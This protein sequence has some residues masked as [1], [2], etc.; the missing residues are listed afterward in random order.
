MFFMGKKVSI[1]CFLVFLLFGC[2][3]TDEALFRK[4]PSSKTT[5]K[6]KNQLTATPELNIL[7]YL[8]FYNGGGVAAG[9]FNNDNLID[10][11]FTSNQNEDKLY[12]NK[13]DFVFQDVTT[14]SNIDNETGWTTGVTHVDINND[15]L[16]DLYVCK[17]DNDTNIKGRNLLYINQGNDASGVPTFKEDAISYGIGFSGFST[18][19]A[20]FDFDLD[21][22]LDMFLLNHSAHPNRTYGK[23]SNRN[24]I[25]N[26][27]GDRL[28]RN[29]E[30]HFIDISAEAGI[31][32]GNIGYGLGLSLSDIN[33]DGYPDIYVGNDFFEN[34][35]LYINQ[36]D[37]TF[38]EQISKNTR[39]FGHTSHFSMGNDIAD[40]N[41]DGLTDIVSLDML[42]EDLKTY[43]TSGL[44]YAYPT[45]QQYLKNGYHPQYMQNT[46]HLN[47]GENTFS[48]IANLSG[49]SASEWSWGA[50]LADFDN[51][52]YKDLYVS[53]GIQGA[54]NDMDFINFI[55]NDNIQQRISKGMTN[56]DM[57]FIDEIPQKKVSNYFF[58][59]T[60]GRSF[61]DVTKQWFTPETSFSN[62]C[63]YADLDNDGDL[64]I[65]VNNVNEEAYILQNNTEKE[66][67][68]KALQVKLKGN[69]KNTFGIGA[70]IIAFNNDKE[71]SVENFPARGYLSSVSNRL[72]VGVGNDSII[73]SLKIVWPNGYS[74]KLKQVPTNKIINLD[75]KNAKK[76]KFQKDTIK[77]SLLFKKQNVAI[78]FIHSEKNSIEFDRDPL[79]PF[80]STNEGPEISV[81]DIDRN[82]LE[83]FFICGAKAQP[84]A[85]YFQKAEGEFVKAQESLF[86]KD[87]LNED[88]S[89]IFF[90]A[91]GDGF[92][93]LL[94]VSG[95]NEFKST[96]KLWPRL[97]INK[98]GEFIKDSLQFNAI[99]VN[100][101][102]VL[103]VDFDNDSD[104]DVVITSDQVP[105]QFGKTPEQY[106]FENDGTGKFQN[107]TKKIA[108]DF[109]TI[110]NVKDM[111]WIDLNN[112]DFKDLVVVGHWMPISIFL[113]NGKSLKLQKSDDI[114]TTNGWWNAIKAADFDNDGDIDIVAG[115]WG[116]NSKFNASLEKPITLYSTDFDNNGSIEPLVTYFYKEK[117]TPFASKDEL[118]KQMPYLNK[119]F[120]SYS[121]FANANIRDLF[122]SEKLNKA[123]KKRV[124]EL[125]SCYFENDGN[126][127]FIK[128]E[129]PFM[130]QV[131]TIQTIWLEDFD[132]DGYKDIFVAG[133]NYEISTQLGR[134]DG[135][136]GLFL[137][138]DK[139]SGFQW[140]KDW[141]INISG[142]ARSIAKIKIG[143]KSHY[144]IGINNSN[145]I[146]LSKEEK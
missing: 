108:P 17:V 48:E 55:A 117:E 138:F 7:N 13:G 64:D 70:K 60:D 59:N 14:L 90:D 22:D 140:A 99:A 61:K 25:D 30:G 125:A 135:T 88:T 40:I 112:D 23:G 31:F 20:F 21:G 71:F 86:Q 8:Y 27:A 120:L 49:I 145:P 51:D 69:K 114:E 1:F 136:H 100:A 65:V 10:L 18:K 113:N 89:S 132:K 95:G 52:G 146:F 110:G 101:S 16:L 38:E 58:K 42:P 134:M 36:K 29:E 53:N 72:H 105:W 124:F 144:A 94:V 66:N 73:D 54:T 24:S 5:I 127:D 131:S 45:Y 12:L 128:K 81:A 119:E 43:K 92:K 122:G 79:I 67:I 83:D 74:Q 141:N 80:A 102:K 97:Y 142:P 78:D 77:N 44:E 129:L 87:A 50:L 123:Y 76:S 111:V 103:A 106:L 41:N 32:Q 19:A 35:Y 115:N 133:N 39:T 143:T 6:F 11:Y 116:L 109:K 33:N 91:N 93:D 96:Q 62:G 26:K 68:K 82:G 130:A 34:D 137:R 3:N 15:G 104:M 28:Y 63:I 9:D 2:Q 75:I 37:G 46:L 56:K 139:K 85:L 107:V 84:S 4:I 118:T 121:D 57:T 126:G 98:K 47:R